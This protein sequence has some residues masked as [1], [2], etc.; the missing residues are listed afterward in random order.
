MVST[1]TI[2]LMSITGASQALDG[3][4]SSNTKKATLAIINKVC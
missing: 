2:D 4:D 3:N 1:G